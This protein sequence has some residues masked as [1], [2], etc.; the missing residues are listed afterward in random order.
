VLRGA[1]DGRIQVDEAHVFQQC[2][3]VLA[4][5][6]YTLG[7]RTSNLRAGVRR[8]ELA[9][10]GRFPVQLDVVRPRSRRLISP[11]DGYRKVITIRVSFC[12]VDGDGIIAQRKSLRLNVGEEEG[13]T[14][15]VLLTEF[16]L[17]LISRRKVLSEEVCS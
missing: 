3:Q 16:N 4:I 9:N 8:G 15:L 13:L 10:G 7:I 11:V 6:L 14:I 5:M 17:E 12:L 1:E 2:P